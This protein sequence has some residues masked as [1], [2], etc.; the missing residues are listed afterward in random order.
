MYNLKLHINEV[1]VVNVECLTRDPWVSGSCLT[2]GTALCICSRHFILCL[3]L[4]QPR[5]N[6][7]GMTEKLLTG[8]LRIK[9][10]NDDNSNANTSSS[11][12]L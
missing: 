12:K 8:T 3:V 9:T 6:L 4:A 11:K 2:G 10:K 1:K 5:K 7:S